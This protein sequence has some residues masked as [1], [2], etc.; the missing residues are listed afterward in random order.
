MTICTVASQMPPV[1]INRSSG[2]TMPEI[3]PLPELR[4]TEIPPA[5]R[6]RYT[7]D[8]F[9]YMEAGDSKLP[10]MLLLHGIGANSLHWRYQLAQWENVPV[11][12]F[13]QAP[14]DQSPS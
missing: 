6:Y 4:V 7:G 1:F 5:S 9:S 10:P 2:K 12:S 13:V 11:C 14:P 8:R 3:L